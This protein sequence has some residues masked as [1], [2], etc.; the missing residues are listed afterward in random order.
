MEAIRRLQAIPIPAS[1]LERDVLASRASDA[2]SWLDQMAIEGELVWVGRGPLGAHDGKV[3]LYFRDRLASLWTPPQVDGPDGPVHEAIREHLESRGASFFRD[4]YE[5]AGGGDPRAVLDALWDLVWS[6]EVTNDTL[7]PLRSYLAA[8]SRA[9][10]SRR[11]TVPS[12]FPPHSSGRWSLVANVLGRVPDP[13]ARLSA[14]ANQL[15]DRHGVVTRACLSI[16]DVSGGF[17]AVYPVLDH[18]EQSGKIRRG[19]FIDGLGGAQFA[20]P[21]AVDRVR[22][23]DDGRTVALAATDPANPY[24]AALD[25]PA[26][27]EGRIGRIAGASVVL[28][29][30]RLVAFLDRSRLRTFV[31]DPDLLHPIARAIADVAAARGRMSIETVDGGP[32]GHTPIG[33]V[34]TEFGFGPSPRGLRFHARR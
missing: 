16:E 28:H 29:G 15:L 5:G 11:A 8:S 26:L 4:I 34:L 22:A 19:Y 21:G 32:I 17:S 31:D 23:P 2:A 20:L 3:A 13:T 25:W 6:G 12:S 18:L 33:R 9:G 27:Q 10:Q 14:W 24:G 7:A 1:V 30:G